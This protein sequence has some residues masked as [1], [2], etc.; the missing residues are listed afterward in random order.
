MN[1]KKLLIIII[2]SVAAVIVA[3]VA[4]VLAIVLSNKPQQDSELNYLDSARTIKIVELEGNANVTDDKETIACFKGMNLY[5]GDSV[6]VLSD[7]VLVIKFDEDK[8]VY[9]GEKTKINLK[10]EGKDKF[11]TNIFVETGKVLAQIQRPLDE[12]EEFFL[13]SNNSVM[14]VRGT[15]FGLTVK[16]V[17][18]EF[19]QTY[20]VYKGVTE[21]FVF[22]KIGDNLIKGKLTDI[23]NSK[24][25]LKV[26]D[27][28]LLDSDSFDEMLNNW[29]DGVD[30]KF[31]D[32]TDANDKLDEVQITVGKPTKD[33]Y[34]EVMDKLGVT[35]ITYSDI[36]YEASGFF[37]PFDGEYHMVSIE[38]KNS[39]AKVYYKPEGGDYQEDNNFQFV[40]PGTYRVYY[41]ITCEG[42]DDKE[43]FE[44]V[45]I[46][47]PE[48]IFYSDTINYDEGYNISSFNYSNLANL[49]SGVFFNKYQGVSA[50]AI[51]SGAT[52]YIGDTEVTDNV[53]K[54]D[55]DS[56]ISGFIELKSGKNTFN[57]ELTYPNYVLNAVV[58]FQVSDQREDLDYD[59]EAMDDAIE[60]LGNE[61]YYWNTSDLSVETQGE[62]TGKYVFTGS[63]FLTAFGVYPGDLGTVY[64]NC[65]NNYYDKDDSEM[66]NYNANQNVVITPDQFETINILVFPTVETKGFNATLNVYC[67]QNMPDTYPAYE[68]IKTQY[69]YNPLT[70]SK[71]ILMDFIQSSNDVTYSLDGE[72]Y[73]SSL[74]VT[75]HGDI[76]VYYKVEANGLVVKGEQI[77]TIIVGEGKITFD[78]LNLITSPIHI[79]SNDSAPITY[80]TKG[81]EGYDNEGVVNSSTGE[82]ITSL[83]NAYL[84]YSNLIKNA[85]FYDSIT[86]EPI[87]ATVTVSEKKANSAN[88][89]YSISASGYDTLNGTVR[90]EN[91][92]FGIVYADGQNSSIPPT[93]FTVTLPEDYSISLSEAPTVIPSRIATNFEGTLVDY[94][95]YYS[96]DAGKTWTTEKPKLTTPGVYDVYMIYVCVDV[97]GN[98]CDLVPATNGNPG[99]NS[100]LSSNG[101]FIIDVQTITVE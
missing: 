81:K 21:L 56:I 75:D 80:L 45:Y 19:V 16:K 25:E 34:Q 8:Y 1:K 44:V 63:D 65:P 59:V 54:I 93:Q 77:I 89:N 79:I 76:N 43:D 6:E 7:S 58:N 9:L 92:N 61:I 20:S 62:N 24:I 10:S 85:E 86:K 17:E 99:T 29:L 60:S 57:I 26:P 30:E 88:F 4:I 33:D 94:Q 82:V 78:A 46:T 32:T 3:A 74:R 84:V 48:I 68:I 52:Y 41:K 40:T 47:Q 101:N 70:N 18:N 53:T 87:N 13:S 31:D 91:S 67:G 73:T 12:D 72:N 35:D 39:N 83:D 50:D 97:N 5:N 98:S 36:E 71:G 90:F 15:T 27:D 49:T 95:M 38:P 11:K 55:Y 96:I 42:F 37:G 2:S 100:S 69:A 14:A 22:D 66:V 23:S 64:I 28:H 51:F